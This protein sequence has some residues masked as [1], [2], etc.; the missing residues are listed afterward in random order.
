MAIKIKVGYGNEKLRN[1]C[2]KK[3][4]NKNS[5]FKKVLC[6]SSSVRLKF[7]YWINEFS[8]MKKCI[9]IRN[10][11]FYFKKYTIEYPSVK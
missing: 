4:E 9:N 3:S 6:S 5:L 7:I 11:S 1:T 10:L 2:N 8:L